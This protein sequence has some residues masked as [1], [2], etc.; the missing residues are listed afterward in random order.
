MTTKTVYVVD[1]DPLVRRVIRLALEREGYNVEVCEDGQ[2]GLERVR[3]SAPD[4][5]VSDIEM[6]RMT[7]EEMC[8]QIHAEMPDRDFPIFVSTSLTNL[9]HREWSSQ[10]PMMSLIE[11]PMS[12]RRLLKALADHFADAPSEQGT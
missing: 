4:A 5:L 12:T 8:K 3:E 9:E 10:I 1:D 2:E 6:P 11:K 7:G